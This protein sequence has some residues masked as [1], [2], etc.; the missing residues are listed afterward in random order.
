MK[1]INARKNAD[2]ISQ[3]YWVLF[4]GSRTIWH[5]DYWHADNWHADNWHGEQLA[6]GKLAWRTIIGIDF[7]N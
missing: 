7:L 5:S 4:I 1:T 3:A 6:C 2:E